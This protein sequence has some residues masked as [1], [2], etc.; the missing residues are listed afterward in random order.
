LV[1]A[2][3]TGSP[4]GQ[5]GDRDRPLDPVGSAA[6]LLEIFGTRSDRDMLPRLVAR[7]PWS[8]G[9]WLALAD[10]GV[11]TPEVARL[12][13]ATYQDQNV[14]LLARVAAASA[15]ESVDGRAAEFAVSQL[16]IFLTRLEHEGLPGMLA[17]VYQPQPAGK[18]FDDWAYWN[19]NATILR[20][21]MVLRGSAVAPMVLKNLASA[22]D[23]I[24]IVC[25]AIAAIRWP[26]QLL[27]ASQGQFSD[28]E[29]AGLMAAV[30]IRHPEL[31][32]RA[33]G[34]T[35]PAQFEDAM[36]QI[37]KSGASGISPGAATIQVFWK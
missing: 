23:H 21:L 25:A 1:S 33:Q 3:L 12:G 7:Y 31:A 35:T 28:R 20:T 17:Q 26:E 13:S 5:S 6:L 22:N 16:Q 32:G 19:K 36:A 34:R 4:L 8:A 10:S 11:V 27:Q 18:E 14:N 9:S 2:A 24:R 29:Y 15:L 30:A 37:G